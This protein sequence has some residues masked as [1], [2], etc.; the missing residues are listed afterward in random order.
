MFVTS[1][2][3][4]NA[5]YSR[6]IGLDIALFWRESL[7]FAIPVALMCA[8]G[9]VVWLGVA[10]FIEVGWLQLIAGILVYAVVYGIVALAV[11]SNDYERSLFRSLVAKVLP[12]DNNQT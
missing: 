5:Y 8:L 7:R 10:S 6:E 11:L 1:G 12:P 2:L 3:I 9:V 4:M